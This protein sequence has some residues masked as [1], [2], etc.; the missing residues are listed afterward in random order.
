MLDLIKRSP[1]VMMEE[2]CLTINHGI[3]FGGLGDTIDQGSP[4]TL[5]RLQDYLRGRLRAFI[6]RNISSDYCSSGG[7]I[8]RDNAEA[9]PGV[10][11]VS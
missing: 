11:L 8:G 1:H 9:S 4:P 10:N 6:G 3:H 5:F 7:V 2:D